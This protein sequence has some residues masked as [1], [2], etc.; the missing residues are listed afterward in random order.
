MAD[1]NRTYEIFNLDKVISE[2]PPDPASEAKRRAELLVKSD[3]LRVVLITAVTGSKLKE[4]NSPG[5]ITIHVVHG[6]FTLDIEGEARVMNQGDVAIVAPG[7]MH[8]V[9]C[10]QDGAFL[11]TIAHLSYIPDTGGE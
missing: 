6:Q 10:N 3:T 1:E 2:F 11:L 7:I 9:E 5:P 4:H 8:E